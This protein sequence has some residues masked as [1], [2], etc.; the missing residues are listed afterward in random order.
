MYEGNIF[1]DNA[2]IVN[3]TFGIVNESL[4]EKSSRDA[5]ASE[6]FDGILG[7]GSDAM[8]DGV[9]KW[10]TNGS[11]TEEHYP[12]IMENLQAAGMISESIVGITMGLPDEKSDKGKFSGVL[13]FG[14][15][16]ASTFIEESM[17]EIPTVKNG[18][19]ARYYTTRLD[20]KCG[21]DAIMGST[22][23]I[24][25]S[26]TPLT[27]LPSGVMAKYMT[28]VNK[29][30][31]KEVVKYDKATKYYYLAKKDFKY[32]RDIEFRF[33]RG[34]KLNKA[35]FILPPA[36]QIFPQALSMADLPKKEGSILPFTGNDTL[37]F[38]LRDSAVNSRI[39]A[40]LGLSWSK[41]NLLYT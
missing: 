18:G 39:P 28:K 34:S 37:Y 21:S 15:R 1:L 4:L 11:E 2:Y 10:D 8:D 35:S 27:L 25:D 5:L 6:K 24:H 38:T 40:V 36:A 17:M 31:G 13:H 9:E 16:K 14:G 29:K 3:Q 19:L 41:F 12:T 20:I 30:A 22:Q 32:L 26:G 7:L 23:V 33:S